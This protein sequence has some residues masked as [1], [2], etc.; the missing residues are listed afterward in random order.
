MRALRHRVVHH[1][2]ALPGVRHIEGIAKH[3]IPMLLRDIVPV[4][5]SP[6]DEPSMLLFLVFYRLIRLFCK[7]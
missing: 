1:P 2:G 3:I 6:W 4:W 7:K 5:G